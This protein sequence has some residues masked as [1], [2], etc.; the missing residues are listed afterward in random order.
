MFINNQKCHLLPFYLIFCSLF[1]ALSVQGLAQEQNFFQLKIYHLNSQDQEKR[2]DQYFEKAYLPALHRAGISH[3]GV[4]KS[5]KEETTENNAASDSAV[6]VLIPFTSIDQFVNLDETLAKDQQYLTAGKDYLNAPHDQPP[7][8]RFESILLEAF[9]GMPTL[10]EPE[11]SSATSERIYELRSYEAATEALHLKK[12]AQFN[13]G[14]IEIFDR[15]NFNPVFYGRVLAGSQMPN[16]MYLTTFENMEEREAHWQ[17]F[18]DDAQ[19]KEL[20]EDPQYAN[21][22]LRMDVYFL[23]PTPYSDI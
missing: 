7:Y 16:L 19:W 23:H 11:L 17:A 6:Y 1:M 20:R 18:R 12:V 15:L 22:F 2:L 10:Q 3:V 14:E 21:N 8:Q 13:A 9:T 5:V 4:F